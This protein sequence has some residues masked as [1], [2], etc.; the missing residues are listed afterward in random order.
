MVNKISNAFP[1]IPRGRIHHVPFYQAGVMRPVRPLRNRESRISYLGQPRTGKGLDAFLRF[2]VA[3]LDSPF[4]FGLY[5]AVELTPSQKDVVRTLGS[6]LEIVADYLTDE[7]YFRR[8]DSAMF[9]ILPYAREYDGKLSGVF[10]D[11]IST[12]TPVLAARFDPFTSYF[13]EFGELGVL[14]DPEVAA[15]MPAISRLP[16]ESEYSRFQKNLARARDAHD[17]DVVGRQYAR[18]I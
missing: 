5:G 8:M 2:A 3:N 1:S 15:H 4:S 18:L 14:F 12:G 16:S 17:P 7:E 10:A 9:L 13:R 6:R 11:A